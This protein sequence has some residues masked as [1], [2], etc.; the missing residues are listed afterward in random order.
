[1]CLRLHSSFGIAFVSLWCI[2]PK[3]YKQVWI[4]WLYHYIYYKNY[5]WYFRFF[6]FNDVP[7]CAEHLM[8]IFTVVF[9]QG[10]ISDWYC[11]YMLCR[12]NNRNEAS[13]K[14]SKTT[15]AHT[16]VSSP[17]QQ[18]SRKYIRSLTERSFS[19]ILLEVT[20]LSSETYFN[21]LS[22]LLQPRAIVNWE[23]LMVKQVNKQSLLTHRHVDDSICSWK[24]SR[25]K[26]DSNK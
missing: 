14:W 21:K 10:M 25:W 1:M 18:L 23:V 22:F 16:M 3:K 9:F 26:V 7:T 12:S 11:T 2:A 8:N 5:I 20:Q 17:I 4:M 15:V 19:S 24:C 6:K 13:N